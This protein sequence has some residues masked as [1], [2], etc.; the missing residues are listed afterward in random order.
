MN[1]RLL[2][3]ILSLSFLFLVFFFLEEKVENQTEI[4]YWK[5]NWKSVKFI[6]PEKSWCGT[7]EPAFIDREVQMEIYD[8]GWKK[9]PIFSISSIDS[10]TKERV[11]FEGNYNIKNTFSDLSVLKTKFIEPAKEDTYP[12]YCLLDDA[13]RLVLS[14]DTLENSDKI[15]GRTLHFGKKVE[16]DTSRIIVRE[17]KNL[18]SP[19]SYLIEKFRGKVFTLRERQFIT[20]NGGYVRSIDLTGQG[21]KVTAEN[22]AKKNQYESYVNHWSRPTGE[23]IVLAPEI[24]NEWESQLK[25]LRADLYPDDEEGPGF[26]FVEKIKNSSP[27]VTVVATHSDNFTWRLSIYPKVEWKDKSYRP[28]IREIAPFI[29]ENMSFVKEEL[30]QNFIQSALKVKNAS[31]FE[32]P[33]QKIQ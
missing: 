11:T 28:V 32:R 27:E 33:N 22:A 26:K 7:A 8:R 16:S 14:L 3:L 30:F 12:K 23:R 19:Y 4:S 6:P 24:G 31:R 9:S 2:L 18:I 17:G 5:E 20:Y 10:E 21:L 25:A 1:K 29:K 13:P 15:S